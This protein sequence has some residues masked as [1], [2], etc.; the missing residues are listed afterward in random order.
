MT[1]E[2]GLS[3]LY[4]DPEVAAVHIRAVAFGCFQ[5]ETRRR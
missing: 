1:I 4:Q 5:A 3:E 2:D